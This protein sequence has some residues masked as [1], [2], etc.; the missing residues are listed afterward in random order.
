V[1]AARPDGHVVAAWG[2]YAGTLTSNLT[3]YVVPQTWTTPET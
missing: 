2:R 1:L 3:S